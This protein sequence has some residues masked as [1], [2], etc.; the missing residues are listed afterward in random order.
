[1]TTL[2]TSQPVLVTGISGFQAAH[3]AYAL[4]EKGYKVRGTV[5]SQEKGDV[6]AKLPSFEKYANNGQLTFTI[7]EDIVKS[8]FTEALKDVEVVFH[9]ASPFNNH[10][11]DPEAFL[12]PAI[13]GTENVMQAAHK[14]N[15]VKH[16][17]TTSSFAAILSMD[18]ELPFSGKVYTEKDWNRATMEE[19]KSTKEPAFAYCA[20]KKF[21]EE[22]AWNY[23]KKNK[24]EEKMKYTCVC[25]PLIVGPPIH[26]VTSLDHL[27]ES[28][29]QVWQILS[30]KNGDKVPPTG[31]PQFADVR[32]VAAAQIASVE[33]NLNDRFIVYSG[34][35]DNQ[36]I[37]DLAV[38]KFPSE[39]K[40]TKGKKGDYMTKNS[41]L[42]RL[43][44]TK[45]K[46]E[47]G[48]EPRSFEECFG[49]TMKALFQLQREGK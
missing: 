11:K 31:V 6:V 24:L 4:L 33:K 13:Q 26:S 42:F 8:D 39:Y 21:A 7:I 32:D 17:V 43:D 44:N 34:P 38:E 47:L 28:L 25:P 18:D 29:D 16:F 40:G 2:A 1:M 22:A 27:N 15:T 30:G 36:M 20:S 12:I 48:I 14:A 5:R 10:N 19:A 23:Q 3:A 37:I 41:K 9:C 45:L 49:D 35:F 46:N